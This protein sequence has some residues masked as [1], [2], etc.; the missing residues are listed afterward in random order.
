MPGVNNKIDTLTK[1]IINCEND[2]NR[3]VE[4]AHVYQ[5]LVVKKLE[6]IEEKLNKIDSRLDYNKLIGKEV[7]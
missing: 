7:W 6:I 2:L 4:E 1:Q 3:N 5:K